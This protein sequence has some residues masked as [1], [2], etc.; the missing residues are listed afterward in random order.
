MSELASQELARR[1]MDEAQQRYTTLVLY[2][3]RVVSYYANAH[4]AGLMIARD[5]V[6]VVGTRLLGLEVRPQAHWVEKA[7][8]FSGLIAY[9]VAFGDMLLA[10]M[11]ALDMEQLRSWKDGNGYC[12]KYTA[13]RLARLTGLLSKAT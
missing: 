2:G 12:D 3:L 5:P 4:F 6:I 9:E 10:P 7:C 13:E 1:V 8:T 11:L